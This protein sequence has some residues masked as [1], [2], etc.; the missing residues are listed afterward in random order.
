MGLI[1]GAYDA[2]A[3]FVPGATSIHNQFTAHGPDWN[4]V[5]A[6]TESNP[7]Q[8]QRYAGTMAFMWESNKVWAPTEYALQIRD[9]D[10]K[11]CWGSIQKR[12]DRNADPGPNTPYP[13]DPDRKL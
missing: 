4:S 1:K 13:F 6:G 5:K 7:L 10:Y 3:A 9:K 2:K 11:A 12:F 8:A